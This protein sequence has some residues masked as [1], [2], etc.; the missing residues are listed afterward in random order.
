M[1][2]GL[3]AVLNA[4]IYLF[5]GGKGQGSINYDGEIVHQQTHYRVKR[6][7]AF[8]YSHRENATVYGVSWRGVDVANEDTLPPGALTQVVT[9]AISRAF[10]RFQLLDKKTLLILQDGVPDMVCIIE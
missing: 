8:T 2:D 7:V 10:Y 9:P 4:S 1:P 6:L 3:S 5:L